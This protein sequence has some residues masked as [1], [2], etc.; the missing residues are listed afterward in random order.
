MPVHRS[1]LL[2][3]LLLVCPSQ[4][5]RFELCKF[6]LRFV[7]SITL[8]SLSLSLIFSN[9][10]FFFF[11]FFFVRLFW[12]FFLIFLYRITCWK[13]IVLFFCW[14]FFVSVCKINLVQLHQLHVRNIELTH[15]LEWESDRGQAKEKA[16]TVLTRSLPGYR[17]V[18]EVMLGIP[19][20]RRGKMVWRGGRKETG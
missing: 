19:I 15:R 4:G 14:L 7:F 13:K 12:I 20:M 18:S 2:S 11:H 10:V 6:Q 17:I 5:P 16:L 9:F 8:F 3:L 1:V